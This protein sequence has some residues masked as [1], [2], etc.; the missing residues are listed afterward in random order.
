MSSVEKDSDLTGDKGPVVSLG[1]SLSSFI[2]RSSRAL[3]S[4][5]LGSL[6]LSSGVSWGERRWSRT[7]RATEADER[8]ELQ[9]R[10]KNQKDERDKPKPLTLHHRRFFLFSVFLFVRGASFLETRTSKQQKKGRRAHRR[11]GNK[12]IWAS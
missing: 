11:S 5:F 4:F 8:S 7:P 10:N 6:S 1:V 9:V 12:K 2:P 3:F